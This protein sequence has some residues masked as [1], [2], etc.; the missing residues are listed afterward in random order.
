M[1][2]VAGCTYLQ[3]KLH[4]ILHHDRPFRPLYPS[5]FGFRINLFYAF[6][7]ENAKVLLAAWILFSISDSCT[8]LHISE[9]YEK[10]SSSIYILQLV[11]RNLVCFR[12][13]LRITKGINYIYEPLRRAAKIFGNYHD[14]ACGKHFGYCLCQQK[15]ISIF[16]LVKNC[17][18]VAWQC[19]CW[20]STCL[21]LLTVLLKAMKL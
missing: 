13:L 10:K 8:I 16:I 5:A 15:Q 2:N 7:T 21:C 19:W 18:H 6:D 17:V 4:V 20:W 3:Y 14:G 12:I 11:D 1:T 9:S